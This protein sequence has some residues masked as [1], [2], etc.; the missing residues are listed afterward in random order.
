MI[1]I[2]VIL[3]VM[4]V[5]WAMTMR[6]VWASKPWNNHTRW[7]VFDYMRDFVL[8]LSYL[9]VGVKVSKILSFFSKQIINSFF[10]GI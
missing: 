10:H 3:I 2:T 8:I 5:L 1:L 9:N 4:D 6:N 7:V